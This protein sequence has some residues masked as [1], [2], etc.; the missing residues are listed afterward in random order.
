MR[1]C[2]AVHNC[3]INISYKTAEKYEWEHNAYKVACRGVLV[4]KVLDFT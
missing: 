4:I 3:M 2:N 1:K